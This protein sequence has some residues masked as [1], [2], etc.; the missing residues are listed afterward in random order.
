MGG[1]VVSSDSLPNTSESV[2]LIPSV[3]FHALEEVY[4]THGSLG[5]KSAL[6]QFQDILS[7]PV[8]A[9]TT[10]APSAVTPAPVTTPPTEPEFVLPEIITPQPQPTRVEL[11]TDRVSEIP[12]GSHIE[13]NKFFR[14]D[15]IQAIDDAGLS[16]LFEVTNGKG[17]DLHFTRRG[18]VS[19]EAS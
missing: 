6:E 8:S 5:K 1:L 18:E 7:T 2:D 10:S 4:R 12:P 9:T 16:G 11:L 14:D 19:F 15:V 13:M 3:E 17:D